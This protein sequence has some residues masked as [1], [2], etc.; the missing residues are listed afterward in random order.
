MDAC[1]VMNQLSFDVIGERRDDKHGPICINKTGCGFLLKTTKTSDN[2]ALHTCEV[3]GI[4]LLPPPRPQRVDLWKSCS[5]V[6]SDDVITHTTTTPSIQIYYHC[7]VHC[8][9]CSIE[10]PSQLYGAA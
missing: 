9:D 2:N 7:D 10:S 4:G 1:P 8:D 6:I 5:D 3:F